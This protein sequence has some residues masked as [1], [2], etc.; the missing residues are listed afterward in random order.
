M[1]KVKRGRP[2]DPKAGYRVKFT[3]KL[4]AEFVRDLRNY[5]KSRGV[6]INELIERIKIPKGAA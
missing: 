4:D 5:A 6:R 1:K 2:K 3:T